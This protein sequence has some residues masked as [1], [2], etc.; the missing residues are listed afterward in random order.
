MNK[1]III[2]IFTSDTPVNNENQHGSRLEINQNSLRR[3][4]E[5]DATQTTNIEPQLSHNLRR[6]S[7]DSSESKKESEIIKCRYSKCESS[8]TLADAKKNYKSCHNCSH[9]YCSRECRR[10]HWEK[11]RKACL[12]SRVSALCRQV[13][14]SC[15]DD[16]D[17]LRHLSLLARKGYLTQGRGVIRILF[18]SPD[19]AESFVKNGFQS[20][21][22]TMYV[23]WPELLPQEMGAELYSEM[24]KLSAEY[25]ADSK[26]L[27]YVAICVVSET[28]GKAAAPVKWERQLVSRCA[29]L[30]LSKS[31]SINFPI[32]NTQQQH[33]EQNMDTLILTF[34]TKPQKTTIKEREK[35]LTNIQLILTQR[36]VNIKKHFPEVFQRLNSYVEGTSN[37]FLPVTLHPRD[38]TTGRA[39]ICIIVPSS[40]ESDKFVLPK[41]NGENNVL[42]IDCL[43]NA[44]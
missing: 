15:K 32:K 33:G 3:R 41:G 11:H 7:L 36:G 30:K 31:I 5:G 4:S 37:R 12:H 42:V 43:E 8:T 44:S 29:K 26:M 16:E 39:F 19:S 13:L 14:S 27:I 18:R 35:I 25:K 17:T 1:I 28:P 2:D 6:I 38:T 10:S 24:L 40:G 21:G 22:E 9:M 23:R 34:C 20:I